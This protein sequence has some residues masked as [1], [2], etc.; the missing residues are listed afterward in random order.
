VI[1]GLIQNDNDNEYREC[2]NFVN[3]W[4]K[5][6]YLQL[7]VGKTKEMV[8]D[9]RKFC[10]PIQPILINDVTVEV[11]S[12]YKYLG[13]T[14]DNKLSFTAHVINQVKK[15]N[16]RVY[17]VRSMKKLHVNVDVITTYF[18]ACIPPVLM[19][20]GV[21]FY[22]MLTKRLKHDLDKPRRLCGRML[23]VPRSALNDNE[24]IYNERVEHLSNAIRSDP[25]HPMNCEYNLLPSGR[26]LRACF[27]RTVRFQNTFIPTSIRLYNSKR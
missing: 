16:K 25:R 22:N 13:L 11:V 24:T 12:S 1:L 5:E 21:G 4:C 6:N 2:L 7:N 20:A 14:I 15:A 9:F 23:G 3:S 26:R 10:L 17:C 8:F 27:A 19:Y 18:N